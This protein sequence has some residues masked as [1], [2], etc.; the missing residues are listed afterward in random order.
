MP[1][2]IGQIRL[3]VV[4][5]GCRPLLRSGLTQFHTRVCGT[6]MQ[7]PVLKLDPKDNVL[8]A[9]RDPTFDMKLI[10]SLFQR[11]EKVLK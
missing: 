11:P 7:N 5:E 9:L 10:M 8:I 4:Q 6:A 1:G 2:R 3:D